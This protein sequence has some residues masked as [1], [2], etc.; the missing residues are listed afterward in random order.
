MAGVGYGRYEHNAFEEYKAEEIA[1]AREKEHQ[2]QDA[3]DQ[4]R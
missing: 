1:N 3:T 2:L 4:I